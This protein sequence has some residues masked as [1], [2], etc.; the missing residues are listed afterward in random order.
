MPDQ[1]I[2]DHV[3]GSSVAAPPDEDD[4]TETSPTLSIIPT[5]TLPSTLTTLLT[6]I[7]PI[8]SAKHTHI[9]QST[10]STAHTDIPQTTYW[11]SECLPGG[12]CLCWPG[13]KD[14]WQVYLNFLVPTTP[15]CAWWNRPEEDNSSGKLEST[16]PSR[17][18]VKSDQ[19]FF[20]VE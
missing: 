2:I 6:H 3:T 5:L 19:V 4:D 13:G 7:C 14:A 20:G 10:Y 9:Q 17:T 12:W 11:T 18:S 8:P 1:D 15:A 16:H